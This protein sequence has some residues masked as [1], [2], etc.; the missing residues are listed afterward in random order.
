MPTIVYQEDIA[1]PNGSKTKTSATQQKDLIVLINQNREVRIEQ[2][3]MSLDEL[4]DNI[5]LIGAKY[6]KSM[7][8]YIKADKN[9]KYDDVMFVLKT[10]KNIGFSKVALQTNG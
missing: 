6:D 10:L 9:L 3:T 4:A 1:L 5:V 2:S 7:P 8:V